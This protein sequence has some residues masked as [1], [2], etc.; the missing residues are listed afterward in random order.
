MTKR[1]IGPHELPGWKRSRC[2][3]SPA[4]AGLA[5]RGQP[6]WLRCSNG[7]SGHE[8][9]FLRSTSL[10]PLTRCLNRRLRRSLTRRCSRRTVRRVGRGPRVCYLAQALTAFNRAVRAR[11]RLAR[12]APEIFDS[13]VVSRREEALEDQRQLMAELEPA[14]A[15]VYGPAPGKLHHA[16][17]D[18]WCR[19]GAEMVQFSPGKIQE[20][21]SLLAERELWMGVGQVALARHQTLQPHQRVSLSLVARLID[22][23]SKLGRLAVGLELCPSQKSRFQDHSSGG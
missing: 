22:L 3:R 2:E 16:Q 21:E 12:L 18:E 15:K 13:A 5:A 1:R 6:P 14:F 20:I 11:C 17:T 7:N 9:T 10:R 19:N 8:E 4:T 23:A